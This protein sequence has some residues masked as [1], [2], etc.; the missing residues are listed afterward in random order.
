MMPRSTSYASLSSIKSSKSDEETNDDNYTS[1]YPYSRSEECSWQPDEVSNHLS[2]L[3]SVASDS[4]PKSAKTASLLSNLHRL[5]RDSAGGSDGVGRSSSY[6]NLFNSGWS[7]QQARYLRLLFGSNVVGDEED[8]EKNDKGKNG[9]SCMGGRVLIQFP[10]F[11]ALKKMMPCV[12]PIF[13]AFASQFNEP[14]NLMLLAS[15][16]ISLFLGQTA[17]AV[18][19]GFALAIVSLVAAVQEYRSEAALEKLADLVPHT[20]TVMRDG[21]VRDNFEAKN[22]VIGDLIVL[23]SGE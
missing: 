19:I 21:K 10:K 1:L 16:A 17:D 14:L 11:K 4:I 20:C 7:T 18:S 8:D 9:I 13:E 12:C 23:S 2:D 6:N 5:K 3:L 22:L 15:A